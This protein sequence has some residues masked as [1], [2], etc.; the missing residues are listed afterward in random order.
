MELAL[1]FLGVL[2]KE[3]PDLTERT[4]PVHVVVVPL[5]RRRRWL[6]SLSFL[7]V[8]DGVAGVGDMS[9]ASA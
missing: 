5:P 9:S 7:A 8:G 1:R 2:P 4:G 6:L 3:E